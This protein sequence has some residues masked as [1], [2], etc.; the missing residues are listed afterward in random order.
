MKT[1]QSIAKI[2]TYRRNNTKTVEY[3]IC[4][5]PPANFSLDAWTKIAAGN[6]WS[7]NMMTLEATTIVPCRYLLI[8][9]PDSESSP[10]PHITIKEIDADEF[11]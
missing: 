4:N 9:L 2:D 1:P 7:D 8:C 10:D 11:L 3:Y 5:D 6:S